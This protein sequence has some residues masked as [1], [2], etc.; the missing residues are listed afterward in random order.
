MQWIKPDFCKYPDADCNDCVL[1]AP[2][3]N[4]K[5]F[6]GYCILMNNKKE[7]KD[8]QLVKNTNL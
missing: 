2:A 7:K 5:P 4:K 1:F 8:E 6:Q 3:H